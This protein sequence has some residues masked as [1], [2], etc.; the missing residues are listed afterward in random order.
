M[1]GGLCSIIQLREKGCVTLMGTANLSDS[2]WQ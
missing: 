2:S 1:D